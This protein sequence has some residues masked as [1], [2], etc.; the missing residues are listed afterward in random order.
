MNTIRILLAMGC[1]LGLGGVAIVGLAGCAAT[2]T[3][4]ST[5]EYIDDAALTAKVK[6]ELLRDSIVNGMAVNVDTYKGIVQ[7]NGF[8]DT[9]QQKERAAQIARNV[10]G[11]QSVQ[12]KL[13]V[14]TNVQR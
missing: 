13:S 2:A 12:N 4:K 3:S 1:L 7:L 5:G 8:V 14:K 10:P 11:V 6:A 9:V